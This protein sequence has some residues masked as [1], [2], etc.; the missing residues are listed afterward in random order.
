MAGCGDIGRHFP[1][2]DPAYKNIS[3]L[4]LLERVKQIIEAKGLSI[5]NIDVTVMIEK[6]KLASYAARMASN[7]ARTLNISETVVNIKAKTNEGMGF[8]GRQEGIAVLA[9]ASGV[10]RIKN[11]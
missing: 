6:P 9:I 3:S 11:D 7:I 5:N 4:V 2:T 8:V 10:E 1:D